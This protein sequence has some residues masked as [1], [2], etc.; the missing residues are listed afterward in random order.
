MIGGAG[1]LGE[2]WSEYMIRRYKARI[3]WIGRSTLNDSIQAKLDR[4]SAF[5]PAPEYVSADAADS[6]S[7]ERA[8]Q[9]IKERHTKMN[10]IIHSAMD[11][12]EQSL[13]NMKT[14]EFKSVLRAK[15]DV[16]VSMAE[17]FG[18]EPLD[19]ALF[20]SS[21]VAFIHNVKQSHYAAGCAFSDAFAKE[22]DQTWNCPVKVMNWGYWG[23]S[24]AAE[25]G[26]FIQLMDQIGLGLIEP[27][28][29]MEALETLMTLPVDQAAF[30]HTTKPVAVEGMNEREKISV[31]PPQPLVF[32]QQPKVAPPGARLVREAEHQELDDFLYQLLIAQLKEAD[33]LTPQ[34]LKAYDQFFTIS[35]ADG[36]V[37][38]R[39]AASD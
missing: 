38:R 28:A 36:V 14:E 29:A 22:L 10:G 35:Q 23:N 17:V 20:F 8:Y 21:L 9:F 24:E 4:L 31:Y 11:L 15:A 13:N 30:I 19:F 6:A 2:A 7:L 16:S 18:R 25:D 34:S 32:S 3:I 39:P 33:L 27:D 12:S 5:G 26:D 37:D 1:Y